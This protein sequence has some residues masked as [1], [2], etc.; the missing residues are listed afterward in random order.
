MGDDKDNTITFP[1]TREILKKMA[2]DGGIC[3][4]RHD[5]AGHTYITVSHATQ[6]IDLPLDIVSHLLVGIVD[7]LETDMV[8]KLINDI[9][10]LRRD[11]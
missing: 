5:Q 2:D 7:C 9:V 3:I 10:K 8:D 4:Q 6:H 11:R 1:G